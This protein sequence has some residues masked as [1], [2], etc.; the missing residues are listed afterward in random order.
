M[1]ADGEKYIYKNTGVIY[2]I[3][4]AYQTK[5]TKIHRNLDMT[6]RLKKL[7]KIFLISKMLESKRG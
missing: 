6:L 2:I 4:Y 5:L 7:C 1:I 3:R